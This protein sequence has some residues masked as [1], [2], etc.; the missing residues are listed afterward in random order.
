LPDNRHVKK[1]FDAELIQGHKNVAA[2]I[3]PFDPERL[4]SQKPLR[5][6]GRRH[7]WLITGTADG[8]RFDGYIGERWG[9]FFIIIDHELRKEGG[10]S[11]GHTLTMVIEPTRKASALTR[12]RA[13]SKHT[14]QPKKARAHARRQA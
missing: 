14:T 11:I 2:V 7:G 1:R 3:V 5:L 4:W 13:Q 10:F 12:A 8:V 6:E 9:R